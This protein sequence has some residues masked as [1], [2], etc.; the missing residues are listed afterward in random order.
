VKV[1]PAKKSHVKPAAK[2]GRGLEDIQ[3]LNTPATNSQTNRSHGQD[4]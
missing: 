1:R 2:A 3:R 4:R